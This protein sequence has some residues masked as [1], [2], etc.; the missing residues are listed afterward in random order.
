MKQAA[1]TILLLF[2]AAPLTSYSP[3]VKVPPDTR[4]T[5]TTGWTERQDKEGLGLAPDL[6]LWQQGKLITEF[7]STSA[8]TPLIHT[9]KSD[10]HPILFSTVLIILDRVMYV[11]SLTSPL[12]H[13]TTSWSLIL[14]NGPTALAS[15]T[16]KFSMYDC[17]A[18][19]TS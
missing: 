1:T 17:G 4:V 3:Q 10:S 19:P 2:T 5:Q 13:F 15:D 9:A 11:K 16:G 12:V 7:P 18:T 8:H 14:L 6:P